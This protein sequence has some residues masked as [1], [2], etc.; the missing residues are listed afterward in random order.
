MP[1]IGLRVYWSLFVLLPLV[2]SSFVNAASNTAYIY[3]FAELSSTK[4]LLRHLSESNC[5]A[6][7]HDLSN[8]TSSKRFL[9]IAETLRISGI[10]VTPPSLCIP[11]VRLH[12][13]WDEILMGY[14]SPLVG[15]FCNGRLTAI[16]LGITKFEILGQALS[17]TGDSDVKV[18][19]LDEEYSLSD[20][21]VRFR[22]EKL[23][24]GESR[25]LINASNLLS[26]ISLLALADSVNPCTFAVF[27]ALLFIALHALGKTKA[28]LTGFSFILAVFVCYYILG[29]GV[30]RVLAAIPH[31]EK[32]VALI[33]LAV[34]AFSIAQ[35]L[36]PSFKSPVPKLLRRFMEVQI[37]KSYVN[38]VASFALG[39]VASFTLLPC[40][41]GPYIV[42]VGLLSALNDPI[43]AYL[44]LTVY[45]AI[46]V[47]PLIAILFAVLSSSAYA[48][49][50][51]AFR[52][53]RLGVMEL[54]SGLLLVAVCIY[55]L[56][57]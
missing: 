51:K 53:T 50:I 57:S 29:L 54:I 17:A 52:N 22:L 37:S 48:R 16:T 44:L 35:G 9:E 20:E 56:L 45:N 23:F 34:G 19:A 30:I 2:C 25:S 46:F 4:P 7:F 6:V 5:E 38:P 18:F 24:L 36:K 1:V 13:T 10:Q 32:V 33:G 27:T 8:T 40:S 39:V 31:V 14:S 26:S 15:F 49:K 55:L 47:T 12:Q 41:S 11:C 3:S 42:G 28:A 43:Q 21:D